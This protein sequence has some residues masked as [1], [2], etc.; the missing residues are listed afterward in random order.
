M[1]EDT[2]ASTNDPNQNFECEIIRYYS[3]CNIEGESIDV[4]FALKN[5]WLI[6]IDLDCSTQSRSDS[7]ENSCLI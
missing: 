2:N 4:I 3:T 1:G 7:I 5:F 6:P